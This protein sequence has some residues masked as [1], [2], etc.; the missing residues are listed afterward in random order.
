MFTI[1]FVALSDDK[2]SKFIQIYETY[3]E[4]IYKVACK[5]SG[6]ADKAQD[7]AQTSFEKVMGNI[8]AIRLEHPAEVKSYLYTITHN[9]A[10]DFLKKEKKHVTME[11]SEVY[12]SIDEPTRVEDIICQAETRDEIHRAVDLLSEEER[13][14]LVMKYGQGRSSEEMGNAMGLSSAAARKKLERAKKKV[15]V[16]LGA[17]ER[18]GG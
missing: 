11:P 2:K 1:M 18:K 10:M 4:Y 17:K 6:D 12:Y 15:G 3:G 14:L 5:I 16:L 9:T 13:I 8:D 7:I